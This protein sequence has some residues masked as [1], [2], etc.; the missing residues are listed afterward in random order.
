MEKELIKDDDKPVNTSPNEI[1]ISFYIFNDHSCW[2]CLFER[3][4]SSTLGPLILSDYAYDSWNGL[5]CLFT[6]VKLV[7]RLFVF[8]S[9]EFS[10]V[11][12]AINTVVASSFC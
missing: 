4:P 2:S 1:G 3:D 9:V 5:L 11:I 7:D 6:W 10:R 12:W 8:L